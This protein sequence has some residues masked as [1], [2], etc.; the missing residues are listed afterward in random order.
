MIDFFFFGRW[1]FRMQVLVVPEASAIH[2]ANE[3]MPLL[4]A[5]HVNICK[6]KNK[7]DPGY[8]KVVRILEFVMKPQ[9]DA[10]DCSNR[11]YGTPRAS[12]DGSDTQYTTPRSSLDWSDTKMQPQ[13]L[14]DP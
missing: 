7:K 13:D 11:V 4:D 1:V 3:N 5:D 8:Q 10:D 12:L 14:F 9:G 6:P 2:L